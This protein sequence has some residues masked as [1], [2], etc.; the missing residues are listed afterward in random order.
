MK[1]RTPDLAEK[2]PLTI[3]GPELAEIFAVTVRSLSNYVSEGMPQ[4]GRGR[5]PV[6]A[7]CRWWLDRELE[8]ERERLA[9][10][11]SNSAPTPRDELAIAQ[12][13]K[14]E[15]ETELMRKRLL[16][17]ELTARALNGMASLIATQLD[18][19]GPRLA[20]ELADIDDPAVIQDR[21]FAEARAIRRA[22]AEAIRSFGA[23]LVAEAA[24][25]E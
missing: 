7:C 18:S 11:L 17:A 3:L 12:R 16:P 21:I 20:G 5:Y 25:D 9:A 8:R 2:K 19:L 13:L 24:Q 22:I 4:T 23:E 1:L 6:A 15:L 10:R 14:I